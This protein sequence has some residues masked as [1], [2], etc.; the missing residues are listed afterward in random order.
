MV[1]FPLR[2]GEPKSGRQVWGA[3]PVPFTVWSGTL[4]PE[5][6]PQINSAKIEVGMDKYKFEGENWPWAGEDQKGDRGFLV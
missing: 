3:N 5:V 4:P 6:T 2:L 1:R